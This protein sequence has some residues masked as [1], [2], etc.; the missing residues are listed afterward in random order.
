ML[1]G[2]SFQ[3]VEKRVIFRNTLLHI[4][5]WQQHHQMAGKMINITTHVTI[6]IYIKKLISMMKV[7][8]M[9]TNK[10]VAVVDTKQ[11]GEQGLEGREEEGGDPP[12]ACLGVSA[13]EGS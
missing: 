5:I 2:F 10:D 1:G 8:M 3:C 9:S 13:M 12:T 6:D 7:T 11:I 4:Y